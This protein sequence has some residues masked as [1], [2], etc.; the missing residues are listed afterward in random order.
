MK[1]II[2]IFRF[3]FETNNDNNRFYQVMDFIFVDY[4][5]YLYDNFQF[6]KLLLFPV[7]LFYV[8]RNWP[9]KEINSPQSK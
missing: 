2:D 9:E 3:P 5:A 8:I 1:F 6:K 4:P 7:L